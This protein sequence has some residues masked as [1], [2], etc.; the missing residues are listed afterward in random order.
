MLVRKGIFVDCV[1]LEITEVSI[2]STLIKPLHYERPN[3][4]KMR[5]P[6]RKESLT[7]L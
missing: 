7:D 6:L 1:D 4:I 3:S 5:Q 2:T